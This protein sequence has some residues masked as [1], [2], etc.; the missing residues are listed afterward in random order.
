FGFDLGGP[1]RKDKLLFFTSYQGTRQRNGIDGGC[2][3]Q[4]NL[5]PITDDRSAEAL[6]ALFAGQRGVAQTQIGSILA[7]PGNPPVP[8]GP[9]IAADGSNINPVALQLLQMKLPNGAYVIPTP[10]TVD[11]SKPFESQGFSAFSI[12][13]PY[14]E[15]QFMT[16]GDWEVSAKSKLF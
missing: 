16:N 8:V 1:I 6:G 4:I 11:P 3:S 5:P 7:K 15:D 2:R 10:Q 13:C 12:A 14:T 9:A